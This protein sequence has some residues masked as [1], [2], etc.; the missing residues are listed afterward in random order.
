[1]SGGEMPVDPCSPAPSKAPAAPSSLALESLSSYEVTL[2]WAAS[3]DPAVKRYRVL[4]GAAQVGLVDKPRFAHRPV[5]PGETYSYTVT[6]LAGDGA[7]S[8]ATSPVEVTI[9]AP[10]KGPIDA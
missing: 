10:I 6:A 7:E 9:P 5:V 8:A 1:G 2:D 3:P 4:R